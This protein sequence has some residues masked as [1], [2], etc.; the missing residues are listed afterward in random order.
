[1][2][3]HRHDLSRR[4]SGRKAKRGIGREDAGHDQAESERPHQQCAPGATALTPQGLTRAGGA[5][6]R[7]ESR[8]DKTR[9][10]DPSE[11]AKA[12]L[13]DGIRSDAEPWRVRAWMIATPPYRSYLV[14]V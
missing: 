1:M 10:L 5:S 3:A 8:E 14:F 2:A 6:D 7:Q 9:D 4:C 13:T 12:Q 11:I